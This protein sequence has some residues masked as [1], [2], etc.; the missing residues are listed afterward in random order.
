M[1]KGCLVQCS[2]NYMPLSPISFLERAAVVYGDKVSIVYGGQRF[3]WKETHQRCFKVA[4]AF[5]HLGISRHDVCEHL[6]Y[7][8]AILSNREK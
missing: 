7:C 6:E 1:S 4:S 3:S 2:A 8:N 5:V